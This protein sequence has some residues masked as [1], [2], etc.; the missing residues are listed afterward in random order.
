LTRKPTPSGAA[1][2]Q[3]GPLVCIVEDDPSVSAALASLLRSVGRDVAVFASAA[4]FLNDGLRATIGCLV[5][6]IR[7]P[8]MSGLQFQEQLS[9]AGSKIPIVFITGH[10]DVEM[11]V[12]AMKGGAVDFLEKPFR[13]QDMLDAVAAALDRDRVRREDEK[14]VFALR[15]AFQVLTPREKEVMAFVIAGLMNKRIAAEIGLSEI[16]VKVHRGRLMRK[17]GAR[18]VVELVR[19]ADLLGMPPRSGRCD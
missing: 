6:D 14:A 19:M 5:V 11:S 17:M 16:T 4:A 8:G 2:D 1:A 10:G 9:R 12:K 13:D 15:S 3:F 7:L 18:S